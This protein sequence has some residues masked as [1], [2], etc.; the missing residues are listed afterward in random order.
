M[1]KT[2]LAG[3]RKMIDA[4]VDAVRDLIIGFQFLNARVHQFW[5]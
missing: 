3:L 2:T 1:P 5:T 4:D